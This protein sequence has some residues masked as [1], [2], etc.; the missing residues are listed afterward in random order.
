MFE[1][2]EYQNESGSFTVDKDG[3]LIDYVS[4]S[5]NEL[6]HAHFL[7]IR[8]D[9]AVI[10]LHI[11]EGVR[12]IGRKYGQ[13]H[14]RYEG[15]NDMFIMGEVTFP[16]T[17]M[18]LRGQTFSRDI[19]SRIAIPYTLKQIGCGSFMSSL[20]YTLEIDK[21]I[22]QYEDFELDPALLE[23]SSQ[24]KLIYGGRSF[25]ESTI[26]EVRQIGKNRARFYS[27]NTQIGIDER[28]DTLT[29]E[30]WIRNLMPE[31][32]VGRIVSVVLPDG[33]DR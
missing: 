7:P 32:E 31:A 5:R 10:D 2:I 27:G 20:I 4:D 13:N 12:F 3:F 26:Q 11:P 21:E 16:S 19:I 17:L 25:K 23:E 24:R 30:A 15:F 8:C 28:I 6:R 14:G 9:R 1:T 18:A 29:P 22:L 33:D